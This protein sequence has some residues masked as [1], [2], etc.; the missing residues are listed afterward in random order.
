VIL[1]HIGAKFRRGDMGP[2]WQYLF[3]RQSGLGWGVAG[4]S[5]VESET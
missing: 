1:Q 5:M 2:R 4:I 3:S